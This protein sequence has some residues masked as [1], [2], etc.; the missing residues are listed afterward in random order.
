PSRGSGS[1][2]RRRS[3]AWRW[4][5]AENLVVYTVVHQPRRLQLPARAVPVGTA[6]EAVQDLLFDE[7]MN[8]RYFEKVAGT[9][10]APATAMF[11]RMSR[12][13]W[14]MAIGFSNSFL[15]QAEAWGRPL[16]DQMRRLCA[17]PNVEVVCVE[18]YHSWL[19]YLDIEAFCAQMAWARE[20]LQE[21]FQK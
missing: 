21:V 1:G 5:M 16:L 4:P 7:D 9:C 11:R 13:G 19:C 10:Y 8:R 20:R 18:P 15:V 6:P 3:R 2:W 14:K 12:G 17:S